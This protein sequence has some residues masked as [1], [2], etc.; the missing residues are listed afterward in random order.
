MEVLMIQNETVRSG[1][2][3]VCNTLSKIQDELFELA[4]NSVKTQDSA[5][6]KDAEALFSIA[7]DADHLRQRI[8]AITDKAS[9][10]QGHRQ[11]SSS[12]QKKEGMKLAQ[13]ARSTPPRKNKDDYPKYL[14][15][16][17][18]LVKVGLQRDRREE[19]QHIVQ[20]AAFD[21]IASVI[22]KHLIKAKEFTPESIQAD[23]NLPSYQTYIVVALFLRMGL[24]KIPRRGLYTATDTR[25]FL[26]A[27]SDVWKKLITSEG[28]KNDNN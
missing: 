3:A 14:I 21:K 26:S 18:C 22:A 17:N 12:V 10:A 8:L 28:P 23:L 27:A 13:D 5:A 9:P 25:D 19:Y 11:A 6:W 7:R 1:A 20:K 24:L 2:I 4:R 15:S 16:D